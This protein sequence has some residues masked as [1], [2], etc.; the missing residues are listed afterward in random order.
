MIL[1]PWQTRTH[2]C[3]HIVAHD[4]SWTRKRAGHKMNVV[5]PCC[6]NRE[7][8][9]CGHKMFLNKIRN[10]FCVPDT[11]SVPQQMLRA[12]KRGNICV[13]NIVPATMC[14]RLPGPLVFAVHC[15]STSKTYEKTI[16]ELPYVST[17]TRVLVENL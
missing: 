17:S 15:S 8:F 4:V 5:F 16:F 9:F 14:P 6:A 7:T 2:C 11:K 10:I 12:G 1:R 3:G 13:G